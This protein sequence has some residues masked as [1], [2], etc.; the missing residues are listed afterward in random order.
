MPLVEQQD[1]QLWVAVD[2]QSVCCECGGHTLLDGLDVDPKVFGDA[3]TCS[4]CRLKSLR[5]ESCRRLVRC[6]SSSSDCAGYN[7]QNDAIGRVAVGCHDVYVASSIP[8]C[9]CG[10]L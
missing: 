3:W 2:S 4:C 5:R 1:C 7:L 9:S 6:C 8:H 10:V